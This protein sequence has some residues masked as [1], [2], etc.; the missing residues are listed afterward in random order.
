MKNFIVFALASAFLVAANSSVAQTTYKTVDGYPACVSK[1]TSMTSFLIQQQ[2]IMMPCPYWMRDMCSHEI[3]P[4]SISRGFFMGSRF[5]Q[6][7]RRC[8]CLLD[9]P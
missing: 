1:N 5:I 7:E 6:N 9:R 2:R 8:N 3:R 4:D